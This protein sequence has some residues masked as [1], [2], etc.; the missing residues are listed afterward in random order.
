M[1]LNRPL[2]VNWC[3]FGKKTII[4]R[5]LLVNWVKSGK[6]QILAVFYENA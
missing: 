3:Q 4:N 1:I 6:I 5:T 2:L